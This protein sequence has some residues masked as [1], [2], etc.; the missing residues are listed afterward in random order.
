MTTYPQ[1][2]VN[3]NVI[4]KPPLESLELVQKIIK[5]VESTLGQQGRVL[6]RY[7]G[8]ENL[9]RVMIEGKDQQQITQLA[10][11]IAEEIKKVIG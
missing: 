3:I 8:T 2:L 7:S 1:T 9:C 5:Q 11:Q 4:S 6:V 10:N